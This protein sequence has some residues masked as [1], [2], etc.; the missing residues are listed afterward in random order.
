MQILEEVQRLRAHI[1]NVSISQVDQLYQILSDT[2]DRTV[3]AA[4]IQTIFIAQGKVPNSTF[5]NYEKM[6]GYLRYKFSNTHAYVLDVFKTEEVGVYVLGFVI[7][8]TLQVGDPLILKKADGRDIVTRCLSLK[9][10]LN[11]SSVIEVADLF[12]SEIAQ[13]DL[14]EK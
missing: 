7:N 2:T 14:L 1:D 11:G 3:A 6:D 12:M 9:T 8:D 4:C 5:L 13:G 10:N